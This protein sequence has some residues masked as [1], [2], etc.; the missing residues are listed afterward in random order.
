MLSHCDQLYHNSAATWVLYFLYLGEPNENYEKHDCQKQSERGE[1]SLVQERR[2]QERPLAIQR[3]Q[4]SNVTLTL[5]PKTLVSLII[6]V[7]SEKVPRD[8]TQK[9]VETE[10]YTSNFSREIQLIT[11][12][13]KLQAWKDSRNKI[14]LER[15]KRKK[16]NGVQDG[17]I[18]NNQR[19]PISFLDTIR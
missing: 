19:I 14:R 11:R 18:E 10:I 6:K 5:L 17:V 13:L 2:P 15:K 12:M 16:V 8:K 4:N 3:I 7:C 1:Q 9:N